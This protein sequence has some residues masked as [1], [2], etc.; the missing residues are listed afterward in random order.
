M[1]ERG[2]APDCTVAIPRDR[3]CTHCRQV[4]SCSGR[5]WV[6]YQ[7]YEAV[8]ILM[9]ICASHSTDCVNCNVAVSVTCWEL[10][11]DVE[12]IDMLWLMTAGVRYSRRA[13]QRDSVRSSA[14]REHGRDVLYR[15]RGSL[16]HL[17]P[18]TQADDADVRWPQPPRLS[19]YVRHYNLSPVPRPGLQA[20]HFLSLLVFSKV[21]R[22]S[23][24]I[25][26]GSQIRAGSVIQA[27]RMTVLKYLCQYTSRVS[28]I[29]SRGL[30]SNT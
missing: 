24:I 1:L 3:E 30:T 20:R 18:H 2:G 5:L 11:W 14:R 26:A 9:I 6:L 22:I 27:G 29:R 28:N 16:W 19:H 4:V 13:V 8:D 15:Q 7:L 17:L 25:E 23:S 21:T 12:L 10:R